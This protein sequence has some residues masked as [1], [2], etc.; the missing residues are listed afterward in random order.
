MRSLIG[1]CVLWIACCATA[2]ADLE[3][4]VGP[5][6][7]ALEEIL[8][9]GE[10][11]G[12]GMWRV[13]KGG[14][15]LW[16][17]GTLQP[18]PKN[19]SWRSQEVEQR[20]AASQI[21]LSPPQVM[22]DVGFFRGLTLIPSLLRARKNPEG[23]DLVQV[24]PHDI[25]IRWLAL[26]VKFGVRGDE[27]KRPMLAALD[28]YL[29]GLDQSGLT[30]DEDVWNVIQKIARK[31]R[32]EI[33]QVVLSVPV[34]DPKGM[35]HDLDKIPREAEIACFTKT[36]ERLETD[37]QPMRQRANFWA[38]GNMDGLRHASYP[39]EQVT[40]LNAFLEVPRLRSAFE[41]ARKT[42][43]DTWLADAASALEKNAS[44][45]AVLPII[46]CLNAGGLLDQLRD[47]GFAVDDP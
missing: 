45:F 1:P 25:Y 12:P 7:P 16:I 21:L 22:I 32:V 31:D 44:S 10:R 40:C 43:H 42:I 11:P 13:S 29:K 8:V 6:P 15:E 36:I 23:E 34:D 19:M 3:P 33:M 30:S 5:G 47:R 2:A 17:F 24:L 39:D 9:T 41:Q 28:L 35:I 20:I 4:P 14:H 46:E 27:H 37:L 38:L 18:L 26:A